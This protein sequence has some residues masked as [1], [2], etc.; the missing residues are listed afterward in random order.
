[1]SF[2]IEARSLYADGGVAHAAIG[3]G[4]AGAPPAAL[5]IE[6]A[7]PNPLSA[8]DA[9]ARIQFSMPVPTSSL[10]LDVVDVTGR[11]RR[12]LV[13]GEM[14]S[15]RHVV[16]WDGS[17]TGGEPLA[18]GVYFLTLRAGGQAAPSYKL[19]IVR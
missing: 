17:A 5:A 13:A 19:I 2:E 14:A 10:A 9:E 3:L 8:G 18:S 4:G 11:L 15:G 16:T 6:G 7:W 12:R 1:V